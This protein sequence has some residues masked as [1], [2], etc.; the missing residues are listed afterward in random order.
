MSDKKKILIADDEKRIT[1]LVS[2][3]LTAGGYEVVCVFDGESAVDAVKDDSEISLVILDIMM[4]VLDGWTACKKIREFSNVPVLMLTARSEEFDQLVGFENGA[5]DYVTKPFSL[6]VLAKRVEALL[7]RAGG[8]QG[9]I[10]SDSKGLYINTDGYVAYI[11][12]N[13]LNLTL[14]EYEILLYFTENASKVL[15]RDQILDAVWGYD[16]DGDSRTVD[17]HVARLRTKLGEYGQSHIKT[18]YGIGYK[19]EK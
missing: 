8:M 7:R 13:L 5:D 17:S 3:Y 4:P 10:P 6:A 9:P 2:D 15:S 14:K 16:F 19:Y 18:V 11:D 12:G 1:A